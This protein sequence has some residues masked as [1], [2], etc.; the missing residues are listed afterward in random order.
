MRLKEKLSIYKVNLF[1]LAIAI[2]FLIAGYINQDK[3]FYYVVLVNEIFII[4]IPSIWLLKK[5]GLPLKEALKL[6][7]IGFKNILLIFLIAILTYPIAVFFQAIFITILNMFITLEVD[8]LPEIISQ[9]PF[10]TSV[11]FI[12]ILPGLCEELMFRA[13]IMKAYEKIGMKKAILISAVLFAL[14]HFTLI[15]FIGP[16]VLGII[17]GIM[18]Y[19]TNSIYSSM[20]AHSIN[21]SIAL[22]LNYFLMKN[23][24]FINDMAIQET[25]LVPNAFSIVITFIIGG[26]FI[27]VLIKIVSKLLSLLTVYK[28]ERVGYQDISIEEIKTEED[29]YIKEESIDLLSYMPLII[30]S[31]LFFIFNFM[32]ILK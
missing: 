29:S 6:N 10:L 3:S 7:R 22:V 21:N 2:T 16:L 30:V 20:I 31:I 8:Q 1:Y 27:L 15:N 19:K 17:F 23:A 5:E 11:F 12:A 13:T 25:E 24:D 28:V 26:L 32:F 9:M 4:A 14:F 18:V